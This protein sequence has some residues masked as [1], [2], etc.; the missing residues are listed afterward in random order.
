MSLTAAAI[1]LM[2]E[3]GLSAAD[4]ADIAEALAG[5]PDTAADKR[6]AYDRERKREEREAQ[7]QAKAMSGGNP[8]DSPTESPVDAARVSPNDNINSNPLPETQ[9]I[10]NEITPPSDFDPISVEEPTAKLREEHVVEAWNAVAEECGLPKAKL[11]PQRRRKLKPFIRDHTPDEIATALD[12]VRRSPFMR[13]QNDRSWRADLDF[14]TKPE[15][16]TRLL[17]GTYGC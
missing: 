12:A 14:F 17:E 7:R 15:K 10:S 9:V 8:V 1:R 16:F 4:I 5:K 13:G 3:K 2:A 11:T 6:R